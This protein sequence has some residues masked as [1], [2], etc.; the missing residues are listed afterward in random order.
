MLNL[1][2]EEKKKY[3]CSNQSLYLQE[4]I[5]TSL[6]EWIPKKP[7]IILRNWLYRSLFARLGNAVRIKS[8]V[9]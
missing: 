1:I 5:L 4:S 9:E 2:I 6:V 3:T 8:G 7:G